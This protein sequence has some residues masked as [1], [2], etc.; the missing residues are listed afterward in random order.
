M[1]PNEGDDAGARNARDNSAEA[2]EN[3]TPMVRNQY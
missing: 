3:M 1:V 2:G